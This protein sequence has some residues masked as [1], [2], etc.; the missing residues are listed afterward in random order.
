[1]IKFEPT[2]VDSGT[3]SV[4]IVLGKESFYFDMIVLLRYSMDDVI[5]DVKSITEKFTKKFGVEVI[6]KIVNKTAPSKNTP[7][8]KEFVEKF[9]E[10]IKKVKEINIQ[11]VEI[12]GR[13]C[14]AFFS[15]K[16]LT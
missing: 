4:N 6:L 3:S 7:K 16:G 14:S 13:T 5:N 11:S 8:G 12:K 15:K 9:I 1:M 2:K 10:N